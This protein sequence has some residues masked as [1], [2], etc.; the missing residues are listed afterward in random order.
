MPGS[1]GFTQAPCDVVLAWGGLLLQQVPPL[2]C[3]QA[4]P[5]HVVVALALGSCSLCCDWFFN[6]AKEIPL[7]KNQSGF[8]L[9]EKA[10]LITVLCKQF[11]SVFVIFE[12]V[13]AVTE[14]FCWADLSYAML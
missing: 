13:Q 12:D 5:E 7:K 4:F 14:G 8:F 1:Q 6:E 9:D 11:L 2:E 10:V 3:R